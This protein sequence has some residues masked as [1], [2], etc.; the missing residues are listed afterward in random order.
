[1]QKNGKSDGKTKVAVLGGGVSA[2]AA[3]YALTDPRNPKHSEYDL[4]VYQLGWR[5]GGKGA[6]GRNAEMY[7]RIEEHGLHVWFGWYENAFAQMRHCYEELNRD[8]SHPLADIDKA[9]K[10]EDMVV[11]WEWF[12]KA[13]IPHKIVSGTNEGIPGDGNL[14]PTYV[15]MLQSFFRMA[16][17]NLRILVDSEDDDIVK[18]QLKLESKNLDHPMDLPQEFEEA[19]Q[20]LNLKVGEH[21]ELD[22]LDAALAVVDAVDEISLSPKQYPFWKKVL[23]KIGYEISKGISKAAIW[24]AAHVDKQGLFYRALEAYLEWS[25]ERIWVTI[26]KPRYDD[27]K[28][29]LYYSTLDVVT[30]MFIGLLAEDLVNKGFDVANDLELTDWL[31]KHGVRDESLNGPLA[32]GWYSL[33]FAFEEGNSDKPNMAAGAALRGMF[34]LMFTSKG[35]FMWK[36]MA[37]MGDTVFSP[38]YEVLKK[39]GVKFEFFTPVVDIKT[40]PSDQKI[41]EELKMV[42]QVELAD[43][44]SVYDPMIDVKVKDGISGERFTLEAWPNEPLWQK[45]KDGAAV[46]DRLREMDVDFENTVNPLGN[47]PF[48]LT[49][50]EHFDEVLLGVPVGALEDISGDLKEAN[51]RFGKMLEHSRVV[52]TQAF[53]LWLKADLVKDLRWKWGHE[54]LSSTYVHPLDTYSDM[55][56]VLAVENWPDRMGVKTVAYYCGVIPNQPDFRTAQDQAKK[57]AISYISNHIGTLWPGAVGKNGR[58]NWDLLTD[59]ENSPGKKRFDYQY[60]RTNFTPTERYTLSP[61]GLMQYRLKP[62]QS[63]FKNL[64]LCGDWTKNGYDCGCV[65]ASVMSGLEAARA[66][67]G[68]P[69]EVVGETDDWLRELP[70]APTWD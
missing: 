64:K 29:R 46:R 61:A 57:N 67:S 42:R 14:L 54:N 13:W 20:A 31:K 28:F 43:G 6:A 23:I 19:L 26:V 49:R 24:F 41:I 63:G 27:D 4:T 1:M 47:T 5:I 8:P 52:M 16:R 7:D 38:Y 70:R 17:N 58:F 15:Q 3:A 18:A 59:A 33:M 9:F 51:P 55:T 68:Y 12:K 65:E 50:G 53:Q 2:I 40:S 10:G 22:A 25:R 30:S 35:R 66:I 60:W 32:R 45:I 56:Q 44:K 37:S 62:D 21:A 11:L 36:M 48:T 34:R 39:R 69:E